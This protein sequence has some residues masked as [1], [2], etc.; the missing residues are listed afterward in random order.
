MTRIQIQQTAGKIQIETQRAQLNVIRSQRLQLNMRQNEAR[1]NIDSRASQLEIDQTECFATSGLKTPLRMAGDFNRA[2]LNAGLEVIATIAAE[3]LRFLHIEDGGTP[4]ADIAAQSGIHE[5]RPV[6]TAMPAV[7][8]QIR[9]EPTRLDIS[10][11]PQ[12]VDAKWEVQ[13]DQV[14]YVPH[15]VSISMATY[16]SI[17]ITTLETEPPPVPRLVE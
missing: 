17:E 16:P 11:N 6:V 7:R 12:S 2:G 8:P 1:L 9:F 15:K 14:E 4:I 3:G 13:E 5:K 10:W